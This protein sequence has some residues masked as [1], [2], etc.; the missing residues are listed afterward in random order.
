MRHL[1]VKGCNSHA[2]HLLC[3]LNMWTAP[4][5]TIH[6]LFLHAPKYTKFLPSPLEIQCWPSSPPPCWTAQSRW[7]HPANADERQNQILGLHSRK[8]LPLQVP[9]KSFVVAGTSLLRWALPQT[10]EG[11]LWLLLAV[12]RIRRTRRHQAS[13][14]SKMQWSYICRTCIW[15]SLILKWSNVGR[16]IGRGAG[17]GA[18]TLCTE[19]GGHRGCSGNR[20]LCFEDV[21]DPGA[22][23]PTC[24][25][26]SIS[27]TMRGPGH[28]CGTDSLQQ[29]LGLKISHSGY[30]KP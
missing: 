19:Q 27:R 23:H 13:I 12:L 22:P 16:G 3:Y 6:P 10:E 1:V 8:L 5:I 30:Y 15:P 2:A 29:G 7:V 28:M 18:N 9:E 14:Y 17:K 26:R 11:C 21:S 4:A 25:R 20:L 24:T